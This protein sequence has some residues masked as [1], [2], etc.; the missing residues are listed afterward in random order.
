[1][2]P[3]SGGANGF[4]GLAVPALLRGEPLGRPLSPR[5]LAVL[6]AF[7]RTGDQRQTAVALGIS[8][9]TARHLLQE[10][11]AKLGVCSCI[12]AFRAMGW[13]RVPEVAA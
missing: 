4:A 5:Q 6:A 13:L 2:T 10:A 12:D 3:G 7:A 1:M 8:R 9:H 11:Y